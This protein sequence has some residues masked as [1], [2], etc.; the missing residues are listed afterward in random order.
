[1]KG[2]LLKSG[3]MGCALAAGKPFLRLQIPTQPADPMIQF[4]PA[5]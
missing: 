3:V 4:E 2:S 1:M 5:P